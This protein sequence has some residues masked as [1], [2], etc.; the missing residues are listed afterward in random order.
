LAVISNFDAQLFLFLSLS[1][2]HGQI[3]QTK[4]HSLSTHAA[5]KD[6][7]EEC[8]RFDERALA[9]L[10]ITLSF[11]GEISIRILHFQFFF[12][13]EQKNMS[14]SI[15]STT[16]AYTGGYIFLVLLAVCLATGAFSFFMLFSVLEVAQRECV[17]VSRR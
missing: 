7:E 4:V 1:A 2:T 13:K 17:F 9:A 14:R 6:E 10:S 11:F 12:K 16:L 3:D 5:D 15:V 8:A